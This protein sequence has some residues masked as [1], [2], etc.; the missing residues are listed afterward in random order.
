MSEQEEFCYIC[1]ANNEEE[2]I[3]P[4]GD[5]QCKGTYWVHKSCLTTWVQLLDP[6][7]VLF[8]RARWV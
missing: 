3:R 8:A 4:S 2:L 6:L 1:N 7:I 5:C